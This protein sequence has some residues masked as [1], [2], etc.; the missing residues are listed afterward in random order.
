MINNLFDTKNDVNEVIDWITET[1]SGEERII[2][3]TAA[4]VM[5]NTV[6]HEMENQAQT[7][8]EGSESNADS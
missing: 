7:C 1:L 8:E 4:M 3:L 2:A 6:M 5:W